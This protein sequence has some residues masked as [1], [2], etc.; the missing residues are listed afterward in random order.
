MAEQLSTAPGET[1]QL[2]VH[3]K[4]WDVNTSRIGLISGYI[5]NNWI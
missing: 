1:Q 3:E 2:A 4:M 5:D